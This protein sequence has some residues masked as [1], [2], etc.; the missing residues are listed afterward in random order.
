MFQH[1][2]HLTDQQ[3]LG[4]LDRELSSGRMAAAKRHIT[5]CAACRDRRRALAASSDSVRAVYD[6]LSAHQ[7]DA[8]WSARARLRVALEETARTTGEP[9]EVWTWRGVVPTRRWAIASVATVVVILLVHAL[10]PAQVPV[11]ISTAPPIVERD[12]LPVA[13]LTPGVTWDLSAGELCSRVT[14]EQ[15]SIPEAVR[16]QVLRDY[17][18]QDV[19]S[20]EYELDYLITPELGGAPDA[21]NLWPERYTSRV[22]NAR[23]K[24]QLERLLPELVCRHEV[25]LQVAQR[26]I[27][28]DWTAAYM[29]Y[30]KTDRPLQVVADLSV[31][32][33]DDAPSLQL[34][35]FSSGR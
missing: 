22:W 28:R 30:F 27:A 31:Q 25:A 26:D 21:R 11:R 16:Q 14:H 23:V 32:D 29:K 35:R 12:A 6:S 1:D 4:M 3:L 2:R 15:R 7:A 24:D 5:Q 8:G 33:V 13:Y 17:G 9:Q 34:I 10:R 19:P 18:M 20:A